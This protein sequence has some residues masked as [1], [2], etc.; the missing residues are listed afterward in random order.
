MQ[1][2]GLGECSQLEVQQDKQLLQQHQ[3]RLPQRQP[4]GWLPEQ[5]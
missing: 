1:L 2:L 5:I 3:D 4:R